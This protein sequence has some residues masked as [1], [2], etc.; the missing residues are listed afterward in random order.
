MRFEA[1]D[2]ALHDL[3]AELPSVTFVRGGDVERLECD[4]VA[5]CDGFHGVSRATIPDTER[6]EFVKS[7]PFG[8]GSS[9][10]HRRCPI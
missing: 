8:S 10:Q 7:Y 9:R 4:F 6:R 3:H 2:V 5:G 1:G